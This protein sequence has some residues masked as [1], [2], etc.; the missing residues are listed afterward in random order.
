MINPFSKR[1]LQ[2]NLF[3][4]L[5]LILMALV[6]SAIPLRDVV[7]F[8]VGLFACLLAL[9]MK[10]VDFTLDKTKRFSMLF[11]MVTIPEVLLTLLVPWIL[12]VLDPT[13]GYLLG[14]HLFVFQCQIAL[15]GIFRAVGQGNS[16]LIYYFTVFANLY[17]STALATWVSRTNAEERDDAILKLLPGIAIGIWCESSLFTLFEWYPCIH[18]GESPA[19]NKEAK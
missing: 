5:N 10:K 13:N 18:R 15:E 6:G 7:M 17:R 9:K 3:S 8:G 11:A 2:F 14:P 4:T 19:P 16:L 1:F 12:I